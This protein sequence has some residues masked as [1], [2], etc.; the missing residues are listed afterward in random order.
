MQNLWKFGTEMTA[1]EVQRQLE[2]EKSS[3]VKTF[4]NSDEKGT[5]KIVF[6]SVLSSFY[7]FKFC[8]FLFF[9]S[10]F[11]FF[12]SDTIARFEN[13][14]IAK[15]VFVIT[16]M[17]S[18]A[19]R[20]DATS[21]LFELGLI[22]GHHWKFPMPKARNVLPICLPQFVQNKRLLLAQNTNRENL[23]LDVSSLFETINLLDQLIKI[24]FTPAKNTI[25]R[26]IQQEKQLQT[27]IRDCI[28]STEIGFFAPVWNFIGFGDQNALYQLLKR[29]KK[30]LSI[31]EN[32]IVVV[33]NSKL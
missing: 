14:D 32:S 7:S 2:P 9:L 17:D 26:Q 33:P 6:F 1:K 29:S 25:A 4:I 18:C 8:F 13:P 31:F 24:A 5:K 28:K 10:F 19:E 30:R 22:F 16:H 20:I 11:S 27:V 12:F 15:F 21:Q 23:L 3:N